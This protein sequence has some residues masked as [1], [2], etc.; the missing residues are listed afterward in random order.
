MI[1]AGS[2]FCLDGAVPV[3]L[4]LAVDSKEASRK[5]VFANHKPLQF[6]KLRT[7]LCFSYICRHV[8]KPF[9][10]LTRPYPNQSI[11]QIAPPT[12]GAEAGGTSLHHEDRFLDGR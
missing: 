2:F 12:M 6:L 3:V 7:Q 9:Q 1:E 11:E 8:R 4:A 10:S 5:L